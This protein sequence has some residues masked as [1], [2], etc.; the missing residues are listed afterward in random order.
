M[1]QE[2]CIVWGPDHPCKAAVLREKMLSDGTENMWTCPHAG[3][4][5]ETWQTLQHIRILPLAR[6]S[7]TAWL[8]V[9][10]TRDVQKVHR[11]TQLITRYVGHILSLFNTVSCNW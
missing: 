11:L 1:A 2:T 3:S 10:I 7:S 6:A 9:P 8:Q 5:R 4:L